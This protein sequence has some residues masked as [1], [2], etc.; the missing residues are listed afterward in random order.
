MTW[1]SE[2][3]DRQRHDAAGFDSGVASLDAW[4]RDHAAGAEARRVARTFVWRGD[5]DTVAACYS[6]AGHRLVRDDLPSSIGRGTPHEVPAVLLA[7]LALDRRLHGQGHGG[8]LVADALCRVVTATAL[9]AARFVV[10]D[11]LDETAAAFYAHHGFRRIPGTP[12][13]VQKVSDVAAALT[14]G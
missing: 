12:R 8:A 13:L 10:V 1:H 5:D 7:R 3:L 6:L 4:L 9:V 2:P 11:A 14:G